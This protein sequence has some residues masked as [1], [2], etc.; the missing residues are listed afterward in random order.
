MAQLPYGIPPPAYR[1]PDSTRLGVV[2]LQV[3]DLTRAV[4]YYEHV[5]GLRVHTSSAS[6][7]AEASSNDDA[8]VASRGIPSHGRTR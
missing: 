5:L 4:E 3:S 7:A 2:R 1:L 6:V 8:R